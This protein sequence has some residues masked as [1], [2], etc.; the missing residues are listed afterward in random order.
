[1]DGRLRV[2]DQ[3]IEINGQSTRNLT[4]AEA[5]ELIKNGGR[6]VR[7]LVKRGQPPPHNL[8]GNLGRFSN[9]KYRIKRTEVFNWSFIYNFLYYTLTHRTGILGRGQDFFWGGGRAHRGLAEIGPKLASG[10]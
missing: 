9:N 10:V 3:L 1:M 2:G 4:H 8:L 7:L 5:I 6:A